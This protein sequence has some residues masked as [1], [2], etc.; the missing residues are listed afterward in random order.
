VALDFIAADCGDPASYGL[1]LALLVARY[2]GFAPISEDTLLH[3]N[4][5]ELRTYAGTVR[6][7]QPRDI[8]ELWYRVTDLYS[9]GNP[10]Q[11]QGPIGVTK[12]G[13]NRYLVTLV[14]IEWESWSDA[15]ALDNAIEDQL[16][17]NTAYQEV[18]RK[19][20]RELIPA[21][22]DIVFAAHSHGGIVAQ[23][24]AQDVDFNRNHTWAPGDIFGKRGDYNV[25]DVITFGSP[26][27]GNPNNKVDYR[28]FETKGDPV[29]GA[30]ILNLPGYIEMEWR[31]SYHIIPNVNEPGDSGLMAPHSAY[32]TSLN[33]IRGDQSDGFDDSLFELP[34][35]IDEW[36]DTETFRAN[37]S[38]ARQGVG[39]DTRRSTDSGSR[40]G[41]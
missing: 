28:M 40:R 20:I 2:G 26:V 37:R 4:A 12:I 36:S 31:D 38:D 23:A 9:H 10:K 29:P 13:E 16:G 27:R 19:T 21:G 35:E 5:I 7:G 8:I 41:D 24:L 32:G 39:S 22:A 18:V 6:S 15:N 17:G 33:A 3:G 30:A 14:G 25:T 34:F 1:G 11:Q